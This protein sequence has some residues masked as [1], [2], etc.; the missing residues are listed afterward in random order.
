M[1]KANRF[2]FRVLLVAVASFVSCET[3]GPDD[4]K[5][6]FIKYYGGDGHQEAKDFV[7]N[8]DGTVVILGTS[9]DA[10][11]IT[12]LYLVKVD[13]EGN[14]L[15]Q[16]KI[17]STSEYA[18]DIDLIIAG[19]DAGKIV[20]LSNVKKNDADSTAIR[21]TVVNQEGDS[22]KS[23]FFDFLASQRGR[24]VTPLDDG[25]YYVGGNTTDTDAAKNTL[26]TVPDVEDAIILKF[27][28]DWDDYDLEQIGSSSVTSVVQIIRQ[29]NAIIF[30]SYSDELL[31][32]ETFYESN[33]V[34]RKIENNDEKTIAVDDPSRV[35]EYLSAMTRGPF[36]D[37]LA[38]GT[39]Q[40]ENGVNRIYAARINSGFT[41]VDEQGVIVGPDRGEGISV[42]PSKDGDF[43][44]VGNEILGGGRNIWIGKIEDALNVSRTYRFG[45]VNN[46]DTASAIRELSNGDLLILGTM[47]LVNQKKMAL[48]KLKANGSF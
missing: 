46:D 2:Y 39:Q 12:R 33:F 3:D 29:P 42:A 14:V 24:S 48:I 8:A 38:T 36:G 15:W 44:I 34:F 1:M 31:G 20:L 19:P 23:K 6:Y 47:E 17:G 35:S 40:V 43:W 45:G 22:L 25:G 32:A 4:Y 9:Y 13:V 16:K 7:I 26:L 41:T 37:Y 21:L 28:S 10:N 18:A 30:A 27:E 5:N 11:D